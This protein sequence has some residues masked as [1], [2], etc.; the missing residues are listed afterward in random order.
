MEKRLA[1]NMLTLLRVPLTIIF[2]IVLLY[3]PYPFIPCVILF[4]L[5]I[6]TDVLDG[7]LTR[8]Y[9]MQSQIGA[10]LDVSCDFFFVALTF[11]TLVFLRLLP[12]WI[13]II[14]TIKFLEFVISSQWLR[15]KTNS[16]SVLIFD[17]M[18]RM[19][20]ILFYILPIFILAS[21]K[22]LDFKTFQVA[23]Q[24]TCFGITI[25]S[26]MSTIFRLSPQRQIKKEW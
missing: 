2:C 17:S 11:S 20:A 13:L 18:G 10:I 25:L 3:S 9:R 1:L 22:V 26:L 24:I 7:K 15:K 5:V 6:A 19:A 16:K 14:I 4:L 21:Q 8:K 12:W 23:T